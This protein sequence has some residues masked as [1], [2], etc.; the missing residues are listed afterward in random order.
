MNKNNI[1][2]LQVDVVPQRL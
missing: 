1:R 2:I